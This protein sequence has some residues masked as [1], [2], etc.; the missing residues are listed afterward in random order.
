[1]I[2]EKT[3]VHYAAWTKIL[4]NI[5]ASFPMRIKWFRPKTA[6]S[7][8]QSEIHIDNQFRITPDESVLQILSMEIDL[9]G[10]YTCKSYLASDEN[11]TI[12][13]TTDVQ[14][15]DLGKNNYLF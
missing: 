13:Y 9:T 7:T 14:I 4:C 1:M 15:D 10:N 2:S 12:A 3:N 8:E 11:E 5:T 6:N